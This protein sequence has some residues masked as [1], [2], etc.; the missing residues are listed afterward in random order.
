MKNTCKLFVVFLI[1]CLL[2]RVS[3]F[4]AEKG[5]SM[6]MLDDL[7]VNAMVEVV[8]S[9]NNRSLWPDG[10]L[11]NGAQADEGISTLS[12]QYEKIN[13]YRYRKGYYVKTRGQINAP[14]LKAEEVLPDDVISGIYNHMQTYFPNV[15]IMGEPTT[16]YNCHSYAWYNSTIDNDYWISSIESFENDVHTVPVKDE[17][18]AVGN[19]AIYINANGVRLHSAIIIDINGDQV[20]CESKWGAGVL[21]QHEIGDVPAEYMATNTHCWILFYDIT[22]HEYEFS[23][24][25]NAIHTKTCTICP[26]SVTENCNLTYPYIGDSK[27]N[28]YC[29]ECDY[30]ISGL[31]C[32]YSYEANVNGTHK[33]T[34]ALSD[35]YQATEACTYQFTSNGNGRH[36]ATCRL[37]GG[38]YE[39]SCEMTYEYWMYNQ[40]KGECNLCGYETGENCSPVATYCGNGST[41][42]IHSLACRD[43]GNAMSSA[44]ESCTLEY[45]FAGTVNGTNTHSRVC[46][47][48]DYVKTASASCVYRLGDYCFFCGTHRDTQQTASLDDPNTKE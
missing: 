29:T 19:I 24:S 5:D 2:S 12:D 13:G 35:H 20:I 48:C 42:D 17:D 26:Y 32:S 1:V 15:F 23:V 28:A 46:T 37:C 45:V 4:A 3:A 14:A 27:H 18:K 40:H 10:L 9:E 34:C 31:D 30:G 22:P 38:S 39:A 7:A 11:N 33:K 21:C 25:G 43:C 41:N 47:E 8:I 16:S 36:T 6:E 44:T